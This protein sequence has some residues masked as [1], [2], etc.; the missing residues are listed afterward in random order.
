MDEYLQNIPDSELIAITRDFLIKNGILGEP[1]R[2]R[3][4]THIILIKVRFILLIKR[5]NYFRIK[6][7]INHIFTVTGADTAFF[8][9]GVWIKAAPQFEVGMSLKEC[10]GIF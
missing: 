9:S 6:G 10:V 5:V 3:K 4:G 7:G 8:N 2:R 1:I